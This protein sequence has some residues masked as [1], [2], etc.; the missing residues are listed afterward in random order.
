[1]EKKTFKFDIK[2]LSEAGEFEGY[3]SIYGTVDLQNEV[4]DR[5]AFTRTLQHKKGKVFLLTV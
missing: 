3:A 2:E 4:V 1:M 5:G